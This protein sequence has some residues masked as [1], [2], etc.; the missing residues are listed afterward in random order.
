MKE[1]P[2]SVASMRNVRYIPRLG[3][4]RLGTKV[5]KDDKHAACVK[6]GKHTAAEDC[7]SCTYPKDLNYFKVPAEF[8][9]IYGEQPR[10]LDVVIPH[11]DP[12][13]FFPYALKWFKAKERVCHG[14]GTLAWR[15]KKHMQE[16]RPSLED[17]GRT[18]KIA[19]PCSHLYDFDTNPQ[20][21]CRAK[22]TLML[23]YPR[24]S[25]GGI[26]Q[27]ST[28]SFYGITGIHSVV[29][30]ED[31]EAGLEEGFLRRIFGRVSLIPFK[32]RRIE[33]EIPKPDGKRVKKWILQ[34]IVDKSIDAFAVQS[35]RDG[36]VL[37]TERTKHL[38]LPAPD[39]EIGDKDAPIEG[40]VDA[41]EFEEHQEETAGG[42][43][44]SPSP[45]AGTPPPSSPG[46]E[47]GTVTADAGNDRRESPPSQKR[48]PG[49]DDVPLDD[50]IDEIKN[51]LRGAK[52]M[53]DLDAVWKE[54]V[55][56]NKELDGK[57][58]FELQELLLQRKKALKGKK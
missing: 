8:Y 6:A 24:V 16:D 55:M 19:C 18:C 35:Y 5:R 51:A 17:C 10:E 39:R 13:S 26:Y 46:G 31:K 4:I 11:E 2:T 48:E 15:S 32:L 12:A 30:F 36:A 56:Q 57:T 34:L 9:P 25:I 42:V 44:P 23:M 21:E 38:C 20:G 29:A 33:T 40:V 45:A 47:G 54:K 7:M 28:G 50:P 1:R 43:P 22:G 58:K 27:I 53:A 14:N 41:A 37:A 49:D 3:H 52:T